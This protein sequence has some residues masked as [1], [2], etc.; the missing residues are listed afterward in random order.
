MDGL[1]RIAGSLSIPFTVMGG[2]RKEH[3]HDLV[4][5]GAR[6]VAVVTAV[7]AADDP[8][9]AAAELLA[10]IASEVARV[11][12]GAAGPEGGTL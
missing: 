11:R 12:V 4:A 1:R 6:T 2:I 10:L 8:Q 7:T 3:I 9:R 5:A